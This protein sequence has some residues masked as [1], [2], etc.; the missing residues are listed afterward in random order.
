MSGDAITSSLKE[1]KDRSRVY[2]TVMLAVAFGTSQLK[3]MPSY[4]FSR[5]GWCS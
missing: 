5:S 2:R 4:F 3:A 1:F